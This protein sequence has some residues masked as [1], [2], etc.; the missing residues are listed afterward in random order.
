MVNILPF[1]P[2]EGTRF[3]DL[4]APTP[5]ERR[6]MMDVC[7]LDARMMRHCRQCR[8]DAIGLLGEDRSQ[9]FVRLSGCGGACGPAGRIRLDP[10]ES[11]V[12]VA[13][14]DGKRVGGFGSAS[15]FRIYATDGGTCRFI[16]EAPVDLSSPVSGDSHRAHIERIMESISGCGTVIVSE[17][18]EMP[19]EMLGE[20][21]VKILRARGDVNEAVRSSRPRSDG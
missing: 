5:E 21:G 8:A 15:A 3:A 19:S 10:D 16:R 18:G 14:S 6:R 11:L 4:R 2:V 7:E 1:I 9:E 20:A 17:I 13:T 12:A